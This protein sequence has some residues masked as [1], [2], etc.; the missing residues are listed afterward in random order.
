MH[1]IVEDVLLGYNGTVMAYGQTG[2][3]TLL[4]VFSV[5]P[6]YYYSMFVPEGWGRK[7]AL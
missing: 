1:P 6:V 7:V 4:A 2:E 3:R 5:A